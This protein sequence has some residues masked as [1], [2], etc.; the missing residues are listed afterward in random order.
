MKYSSMKWVKLYRGS[1]WP[2]SE[3]LNEI[4]ETTPGSGKCIFAIQLRILFRKWNTFDEVRQTI[5]GWLLALGR[6]TELRSLKLPHVPAKLYVSCWHWEVIMMLPVKL[7]YTK[8]SKIRAGKNYQF[9]VL[10]AT[11]P[12]KYKVFHL[13]LTSA[14]NILMS[15]GAVRKF[16][17]WK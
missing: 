11:W 16:T 17:M 6:T 15:F 2:Q 1:F 9:R 13:A 8:V 7:V 14:L 12:I 5:Q 10:L 3:L 4:A